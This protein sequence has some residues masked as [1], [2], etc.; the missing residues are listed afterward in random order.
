MK[1]TGTYNASATVVLTALVA[2]AVLVG[3]DRAAPQ[4]AAEQRFAWK[5]GE[6]HV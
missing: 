6:D 3:P 2:A 1:E 4:P 5:D